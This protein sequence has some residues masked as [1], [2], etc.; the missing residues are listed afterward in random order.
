VCCIL[1]SISDI[2]EN[3]RRG[4]ERERGRES[5]RGRQV[6]NAPHVSGCQRAAASCINKILADD[7]NRLQTPAICKRAKYVSGLLG[8]TARRLRVGERRKRERERER[9]REGG[10][11]SESGER[12]RDR[13][14]GAGRDC[15]HKPRNYAP[16]V[17]KPVTEIIVNLNARAYTRRKCIMRP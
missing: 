8:I 11:G 12:E 13:Q 7:P 17:C 1:F 16:V 15:A 4:R 10:G 6:T 14:I 9:E 3:K 2:D 5:E